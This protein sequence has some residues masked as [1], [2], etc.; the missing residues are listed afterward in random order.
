MKSKSS[1]YVRSI[2]T[3]SPKFEALIN[4]YFI[5][6]EIKMFITDTIFF[7]GNEQNKTNEKLYGQIFSIQNK[8]VDQKF[9]IFYV[10]FL[11]FANYR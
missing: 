3:P 10:K 11:S 5:V 2:H 7:F 9:L 1:P 8:N 6:E 4:L